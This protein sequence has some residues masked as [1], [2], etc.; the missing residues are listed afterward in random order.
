M[1]RI[2]RLVVKGKKAVY[3][4]MTR[5]ALDGYVL[6]DVE[7]DFLLRHIRWLGK[8]YFVEVLSFCI[9]GK[10]FHLL[11]RMEPGENKPIDNIR[12]RFEIYYRD[13]GKRE[14][15]EQLVPVLRDERGSLSE[16]VKEIKQG[17]SRFYNKRHGRKGLFLSERFKSVIVDNGGTLIN[18]L[19]YIDL[20]ST[21]G[22]S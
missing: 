19:A 20:N 7:K 14:L 3:H 11:A 1:P 22:G 8:V 5:T 2:A 6:E 4:V 21:V 15:T 13:D 9:M 17:F 12:R 18:C 16:F 10:H